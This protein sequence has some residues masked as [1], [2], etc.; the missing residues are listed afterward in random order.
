MKPCL[1]N[2]D[3]TFTVDSNWTSRLVNPPERLKIIPVGG[4]QRAKEQVFIS[5]FN[6]WVYVT[7]FYVRSFGS[8]RVADI[9]NVLDVNAGYGR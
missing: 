2:T 8:S 4:S 1:E 5:D 6:Y 3:M 7:D 9:R